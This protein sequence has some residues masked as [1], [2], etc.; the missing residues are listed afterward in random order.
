MYTFSI[1]SFCITYV[2]QSIASVFGL[3]RTNSS[4]EN[5]HTFDEVM[6]YLSHFWK[7]KNQINACISDH[8]RDR[9]VKT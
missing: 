1:G 7:C 5:F 8:I 3:A 2:W 6:T 9:N 4:L